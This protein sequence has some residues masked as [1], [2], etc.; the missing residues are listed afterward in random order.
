[1]R[2]IPCATILLLEKCASQRELPS[3]PWARVMAEA[4][5]AR[6][7]MTTWL[8]RS[9]LAD[10]EMKALC[11]ADQSIGKRRSAQRLAPGHPRGPSS[12][13][14]RGEQKFLAANQQETIGDELGFWETRASD[15]F[16][17]K[18]FRVVEK[19]K[20]PS[21]GGSELPGSQFQWNQLPS[22]LYISPCEGRRS[23]H[24]GPT[25]A[26]CCCRSLCP[27]PSRCGTIRYGRTRLRGR[28]TTVYGYF[29]VSI[30]SLSN[31]R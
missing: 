17:R 5:L 3:Q 25:H 31:Q 10:S 18:L 22:P 28:R 14:L 15:G 1:M 12:S 29:I 20:A 27:V 8:A 7:V 30:F 21:F 13:G 23:Q 4:G 2:K 24:R 26:G 19:T 9:M 6:L 16:P 11:T